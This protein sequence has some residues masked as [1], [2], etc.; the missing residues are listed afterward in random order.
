MLGGGRDLQ[1][2][3]QNMPLPPIRHMHTHMC[4]RTAT[5]A[6]TRFNSK[7][8]RDLH[9]TQ[10]QQKVHLKARD[11]HTTHSP[12]P[13]SFLLCPILSLSYMNSELS[14]FNIHTHTHTPHHSIF[15]SL[16]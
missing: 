14:T 2:P 9:T 3:Y 5:P 4:Q 1:R 13:T 6:E 15:L 7:A 16:P 11:L 8:I 10:D 12:V